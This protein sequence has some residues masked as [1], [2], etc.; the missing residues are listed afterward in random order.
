ML[1]TDARRPARTTAN[2]E[3]VLLAEQDRTLWDADKIAEG[4]PL[5]TEAL[6]RKGPVYISSRRREPHY[7]MRLRA[8]RRQ[9]GRKSRRLMSCCC[10]SPTIR[11]LR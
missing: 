6:P 4:V 9:T 1:L 2:G 11:S 8:P 10:R 5:I 3:L 7:T